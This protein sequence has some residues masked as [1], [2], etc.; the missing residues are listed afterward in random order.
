M[1][2][3]IIEYLAQGMGKEWVLGTLGI[4]TALFDEMLASDGMTD[5]ISA[6]ARTLLTERI[7][8][9]YDR[10]E[11]SVLKQID[12][13]MD[14]FDANG[15]CRILETVAKTRVLKSA[16]LPGHYTGPATQ[17]NTIV[18]VMP[19]N[20]ASKEVVVNSTNEVIAI[21]DRSMA[22]MALGNVK[23]LFSKMKSGMHDMREQAKVINAHLGESHEAASAA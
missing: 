19:Q 7:A 6:R 12:K 22:P 8:L 9:K 5:E 23:D 14:E 1:R 18:L 21:G 13:R 15:L 10:M 17:Q 11:E 16:A 20:M 4:S 2:Q 3:Q